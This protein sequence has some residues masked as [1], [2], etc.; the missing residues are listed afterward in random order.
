MQYEAVFTR[1]SSREGRRNCSPE[2]F[3]ASGFRAA[4]DKAETLLRGM[5]LVDDKRSYEIVSVQAV[6]MQGTRCQHGWLTDDEFS[7]MIERDKAEADEL[8]P[9]SKRARSGKTAK[10]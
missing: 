4:V 5:R 9:K 7:A 6:G 3:D 2:F 1:Y 8:A 10:A